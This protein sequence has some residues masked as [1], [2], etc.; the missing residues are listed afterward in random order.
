MNKPQES[1]SINNNNVNRQQP[2]S[3]ISSNNLT[4]K[5]NLTA[6][7]VNDCT[8]QHL[9]SDKKNIVLS[10]MTPQQKITNM[11]ECL[12]LNN[13]NFMSK[14]EFCKGRSSF[15]AKINKFQTNSPIV[16][17]YAGM[18]QQ[19][20]IDQINNFT[21]EE[22]IKKDT[23]CYALNRDSQ[24]SQNFNFSPSNIF[25]KNNSNTSL[26]LL[27]SP[28]GQNR[29]T[30]TS[31]G[32]VKGNDSDADSEV[33]G[34][35]LYMLSFISDEDNN[36]ASKENN[37][38][39]EERSLM[40]EKEEKKEES[41]MPIQSAINKAMEKSQK[42]PKNKD[43]KKNSPKEES[44][45]KEE[46]NTN[47][48]EIS[49]TNNTMNMIPSYNMIPTP[50]LISNSSLFD[51]TNKKQKKIKRLD[52]SAYTDHPL[53]DLANNLFFIAKDQG[54][55]RY[56]QKLL[57]DDP[58]NVTKTLYPSLL[59]NI[60][61]LVNDP[62]GNYF[63]QKMFCS[64]SQDQ[65]HQIIYIF[66]PHFFDIGA[67]P[68]GTRVLQQ[69]IN[70]LSSPFLIESFLS[71]MTPFIVPLLKELNGTHVVQRFT[72][73]YPS[74]APYVN[75]I[76]VENSPILATHRHGCCVVQKYL[77]TSTG[78]MLH[79]LL[80]K[81]VCNC[82]M[83]IIDQFGNYVIQSILLMNNRDCGNAIAMRITDNV[84]YYAK[85]KYSSN[86]VEKC[87]DYCDGIVK[88]KLLYTLMR[89]EAISDLILDEHGNYVIQK[90]ISLVD[91]ASRKMML[92]QIIPLFGKLK[93]VSYGER[94]INRLLM[95][96]PELVSYFAMMRK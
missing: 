76:I 73:V 58:I 27:N 89:P 65:I 33:S 94:V 59:Q 38:E 9:P 51:N 79:M 60:L 56:L 81:L 88:Q 14:A 3:T 6:K 23:P 1:E 40:R 4:H 91:P 18:N 77:E 21:L 47:K 19:C 15:N 2:N 48:E 39:K 7:A 17:Y 50:S 80:E 11:L 67:N 28:I 93:M 13:K 87:F 26:L 12:E 86:V 5:F 37:E 71:A 68:H 44:K 70:Y 22:Q 92:S 69:L 74:Y 75:N 53:E 96:Y 85:H 78:E 49:S 54:G 61:K 25:N 10:P 36:R 16:Q 43:K 72:F 41:H 90:V 57:D 30:G 62:F 24:G 63:I 8:P 29:N 45:Q 46:T 66:S 83:L 55:C 64:L 31:L 95:S 32:I 42:S 35:D 20:K 52:P 84:C 34:K 82:L